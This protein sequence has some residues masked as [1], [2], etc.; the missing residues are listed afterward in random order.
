MIPAASHRTH[1]RRSRAATLCLAV[2]AIGQLLA[3]VHRVAIEHVQCPV[4]GDVVHR[5]AVHDHPLSTS[6]PAADRA[7]D[8]LLSETTSTADGEHEDCAVAVGLGGGVETSPSLTSSAPG[9]HRVAQAIFPAAPSLA[10]GLLDLAPKTS[11]PA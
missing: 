11:P 10:R 6:A 3:I 9:G 4:H 2:L 1:K 7:P 8:A 5:D